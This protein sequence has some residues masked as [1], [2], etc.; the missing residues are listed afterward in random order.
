MIAFFPRPY[1]DE[2]F[3]SVVGRCARVLKIPEIRTFKKALFNQS[4]AVVSVDFPS[5]LTFFIEGLYPN[6]SLTVEK[7]VNS[8]SFLPF[9]KCF[10]PRE[11]YVSL[12]EDMKT[13]GPVHGGRQRV[14]VQ[15][16]TTQFLHRY[17]H[18]CPLCVNHDREVYGETYWHRIHQIAC[19]SVCPTHKCA[20][21]KSDVLMRKNDSF[22]ETAENV[23]TMEE[24]HQLI[25]TQQELSLFLAEQVHWLFQHTKEVCDLREFQKKIKYILISFGL[26][27]KG[28][29]IRTGD[30][31]TLFQ[32]EIDEIKALPDLGFDM[33]MQ[34]FSWL[35]KLLRESS[36]PTNPIYF[37]IA[38]NFLGFSIE[39]ACEQ[40]TAYLP[41]GSG[42]WFCENV[43]C[44]DHKKRVIDSCETKIVRRR[45]RE[46]D[47]LRAFFQCPTCGYLYSANEKMWKADDCR[48][49]RFSIRD[50]GW[51]WQNK[52]I[53]LW[54]NRRFSVNA[55]SDT[56]GVKNK[57]VK[58]YA[59]LLGLPFSLPNR[60]HLQMPQLN[61]S[62]NRSVV[63][64]E[65]LST[66]RTEWEK[67]RIEN[68]EMSRSKLEKKFKRV[69]SWLRRNDFAWLKARLPPIAQRFQPVDWKAEDEKFLVEVN[70]AIAQILSE[71]GKPVRITKAEISRRVSYDCR[72]LADLNRMPKT[73]R[74]VEDALESVEDVGF[75]RIEWATNYFIAAR[76][77]PSFS[78]FV[79]VGSLGSVRTH[80]A[81]RH[82]IYDSIKK[83]EEELLMS[84]FQLD[85]TV[86]ID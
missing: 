60:N 47:L 12:V 56:L 21:N 10:L 38:L 24:P 3:S 1:P 35:E 72:I 20:L 82:K 65:Q 36:H 79:K 83:I 58:R 5:N 50:Y 46:E 32:Q 67:I 37:L 31:K 73:K 7:I 14:G 66:F 64:N 43:I 45:N 28:G 54:F 78:E 86:E 23:I 13:E 2:I 75:R 44:P 53:E 61:N 85:I 57:T 17:F 39:S 81:F 59:M 26:A 84:D 76:E 15:A 27:S 19:V 11:R 16:G 29:T 69:V 55:I 51:L 70:G 18:S 30:L 42:P 49:E 77:I 40:P 34:S 63:S 80:Y 52:L 6:H 22:L 33:E 8:H 9:F 25:R 68:P 74:I 71:P 41:F 4:N 48:A 62:Q